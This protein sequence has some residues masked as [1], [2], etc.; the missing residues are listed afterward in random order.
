M[1]QSFEHYKI[2]ILSMYG[3]YLINVAYN[4]LLMS[5]AVTEYLSFIVA[6]P[7]MTLVLNKT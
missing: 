2:K 1:L 5:L 4:I 7:E 3:S 6:A